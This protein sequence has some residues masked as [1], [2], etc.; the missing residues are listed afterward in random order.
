MRRNVTVLLSRIVWIWYHTSW[1]NMDHLDIQKY[2]D[3]S[4][5]K[6]DMVILGTKDEIR[7]WSGGFPVSHPEWVT[8]GDPLKYPRVCTAV[9]PSRFTPA[10]RRCLSQTRNVVLSP[11][12]S[13][14]ISTT[15][16]TMKS[17]RRARN[18]KDSTPRHPA[19]WAQRSKFSHHWKTRS[20]AKRQELGC[21]SNGNEVCRG[22]KG[23][24]EAILLLAKGR[25]PSVSNTWPLC[26][27]SSST[28][29]SSRRARLVLNARLS[30]SPQK[31]RPHYRPRLH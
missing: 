5:D 19:C 31:S 29:I 20:A 9:Q 23:A 1:K 6:H 2:K 25:K 17:F 30:T 12:A 24:H 16:T 18:H 11:L 28:Q 10:L 13:T 15:N 14:G 4:H 22:D 7:G 21:N 8:T 26:I 27:T 3:R